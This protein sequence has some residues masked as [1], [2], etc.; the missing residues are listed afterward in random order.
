MYWRSPDN[1]SEWA[2]PVSRRNA[3]VQF[4]GVLAVSLVLAGVMLL[5]AGC[6]E[7]SPAPVP[8]PIPPTARAMPTPSATPNMCQ[9]GDVVSYSDAYA[10]YRAVLDGQLA[11]L[12]AVYATG[13]APLDDAAV[14]DVHQEIRDA[15]ISMDAMEPPSMF[16]GVELH[17]ASYMESLFQALD[18]YQQAKSP[19][20]GL[21]IVQLKPEHNTET[22]AAF[23]AAFD[24]LSAVG[25]MIAEKCPELR[26]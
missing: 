6:S 19:V 15:A 16:D 3:G 26:Q 23:A 22:A 25:R 12:D 21:G 24:E 8:T 11:R 4:M 10:T 13:G 2:T 17:T 18:L 9:S 5:S 7:P 14:D 1:Q 20:V